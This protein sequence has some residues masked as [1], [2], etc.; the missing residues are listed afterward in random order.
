MPII[1]AGLVGELNLDGSPNSLQRV[2]LAIHQRFE[3]HAQLL[4]SPAD[5]DSLLTYL[6]PIFERF[7]GC[8]AVPGQ[9][10]AMVGRQGQPMDLNVLLGQVFERGNGQVLF[11]ACYQH[12][13]CVPQD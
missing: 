10:G 4:A 5:V 6:V 2:E 12:L 1:D 8:Q 11:M 9:P 3:S 7:A 13:T